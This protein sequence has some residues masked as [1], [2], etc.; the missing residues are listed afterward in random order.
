MKKTT[1]F[2][3][4]IICLLGLNPNVFSQS[5]VPDAREPKAKIKPVVPL[6]AYAFPLEDLRLLPGSAFYNAME[7]DAA[8]L[9]K[10]ESDRL[11]HR[12]Y[13]NAGLPTKAPVY[14]GWESEGLS[15]HT[16]GHYLSACALMYAGSKD[17]KYLERVNYLVQ[18]LARCQVARKTGYV[19]AIPKEDSIFAQVARGDI[20]SSGFD[21]NGGWSPWYTIHKVMAGLADAYL[22]TNND[23][24]L[25]VLRGMSDWTASVVDKLNDPQ[26]Q[27]M[28]KCEYGGMNEI[29]ANVYAFTGEKK[30]LDLSYKFY[31][32][33][34]MEPL[35]KK[36]DPLPGKHSNTNVPKAIGS[37]R[38]YELT[39]N[40]RD[41]T[42]ASFF[43][44]TMVH[45]HTYVIGG[46][47]NYEYC[48]DAGKLND[49]LSDNTCETCNT[50]NMLKL[51]RHLFCWQPSAEL[52]DY[53]ERAL[54]N[55]ILAS[56][57]PETGMM[58]YFVPL[59]MG[60]KKEFSNEFHT[61]TCC[62]GSGMENHVK[63]TESIYYRG[64]DGNSL[65]LNLFIPSELNWK[66]RGLT[67][68]QETKF[69]QDG[70]VTLSFTCAKSQKLALNLRRPWWMKADWQIKV[71]GKAVQP[72]AG[73]N[74]YYV[75]NRRWKNGDKLE[76]E[77][78]MQLYTE[79]MPDNPNRI[80]FLYGPLVLAGQLGDKMPDPVY[81]TPVLLSAERRAEQ[82]VQTQDLPTLKF[83]IRPEV[84]KP[85]APPLIP[86]Y[87]S[88]KEYYSV[89]WD[90]FSPEQWAARQAEY[91]AEKKR[92]QMIEA[93]TLDFF[94][95]GEMQPERDHKLEASERSYVSDALGVNG[96]EARTGHYFAF[97]M[98]VR[99]V[100][101]N[102]LLF[103]YIGDDKDRKFDIKVNGKVLLTETLQGGQVGRFYDREYVIPAE[104]LGSGETITIRVE[105]NYGKT[106]GRVFGARVLK[107]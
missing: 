59:R 97:E 85:L 46:N 31:D 76:L 37:A 10:I 25:Q 42:I 7:K 66:E 74:G 1:P 24:A 48:G 21:L 92:Q 12:F 94:R 26:R 51:T 38:Q 64:Q 60:S 6:Q 4:F 81:G 93:Q 36:I 86:F 18:E 43:W 104:M 2:L 69:P 88:N 15:G 70:K 77:M 84:A 95:I 58:T 53:Y 98:K 19:G 57:H 89:Y 13:A 82:L 102:R 100:V 35:S 61:F 62:V 29:L 30:Y 41:Q 40:T 45:N 63:Y 50:Y 105:A 14:G 3:A 83:Q 22:Y 54:Y 67:L 32:D 47:S 90:Y 65:Y 27:K 87:L 96:R 99:P 11:L 107:E 23:Q 28:L 16:L 5:Y 75:L 33:F 55:H 73:T 44:E 39:G 8:Y 101:N 91:E 9:L 49:R 103:T 20:R 68:R 56:Q 52:A 79:S 72:V 17:E 78:P 106:A 34:V 71:N 80:A